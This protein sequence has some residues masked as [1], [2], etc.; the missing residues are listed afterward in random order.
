MEV[1][2]GEGVGEGVG[3]ES[4]RKA[5]SIM[6]RNVNCLTKAKMGAFF[7]TKP[8]ITFKLFDSL[9]KPIL[10]Y[11]SEVWGIDTGLLPNPFP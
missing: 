1:G 10:Q 6:T 7:R 2:V 11:G 8:R 5:G 4:W 3:W 9:V